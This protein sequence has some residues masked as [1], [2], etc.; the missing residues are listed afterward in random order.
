M[1]KILLK[2]DE[3]LK[4]KH[5]VKSVM[6]TCA[7]LIHLNGPIVQFAYGLHLHVVAMAMVQFLA[8]QVEVE[9]LGDV[10][11]EIVLVLSL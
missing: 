3:V 1:L 7:I 8:G 5:F 4:Q 2:N 11:L 9:V 6:L 10:R